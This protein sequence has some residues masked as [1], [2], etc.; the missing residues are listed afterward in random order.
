MFRCGARAGQLIFLVFLSLALAAAYC[1]GARTSRFARGRAASASA[2]KAATADITKAQGS[3]AIAP[4]R[5]GAFSEVR[6][7][8]A[9]I[10]AK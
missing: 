2:E 1:Y 10:K 3:L 7:I 4:G 8:S 9:Q 5:M 6:S